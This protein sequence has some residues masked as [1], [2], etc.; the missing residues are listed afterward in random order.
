M[1]LSWMRFALGQQEL[2]GNV[3]EELMK[4]Q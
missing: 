4:Q 1:E 3:E 2:E